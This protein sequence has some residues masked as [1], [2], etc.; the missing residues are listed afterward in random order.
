MHQQTELSHYLRTGIKLVLQ[1]V[2]LICFLWRALMPVLLMAR[3]GRSAC[4]GLLPQAASG[5][6]PHDGV[7]PPVVI[8]F[9]AKGTLTYSR[10]FIPSLSECQTKVGNLL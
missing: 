1:F 4:S 8:A 3:A 10:A 5:S 6:A 2:R 9:E 7:Q